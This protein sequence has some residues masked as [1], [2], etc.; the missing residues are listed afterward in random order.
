[1]NH[2]E[3]WTNVLMLVC[4]LIIGI[5]A[6]RIIDGRAAATPPECGPS[7]STAGNAR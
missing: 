5:G 2:L 6:A 1:M 4:G 3:R 7:Q